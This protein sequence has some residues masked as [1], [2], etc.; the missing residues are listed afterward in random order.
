MIPA[1]SLKIGNTMIFLGGWECEIQKVEII[2]DRVNVWANDSPTPSFQFSS[3]V[4][5]GIKMMDH[6]F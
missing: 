1:T 4:T 3:D 2:D 6:E 5:V